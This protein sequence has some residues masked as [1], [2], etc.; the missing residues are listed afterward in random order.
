MCT[1]EEIQMKKRMGTI[2]IGEKLKT[3]HVVFS[4]LGKKADE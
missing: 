2:A 3:M 1:S 4:G